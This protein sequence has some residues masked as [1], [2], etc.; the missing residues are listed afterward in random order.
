LELIDEQG[1][2]S[3]QVIEGRMNIT[4]HNAVLT[5]LE[6]RANRFTTRGKLPTLDE[7]LLSSAL[8]KTGTIDVPQCVE[9]RVDGIWG[10]ESERLTLLKQQEHNNLR[11]L[12]IT[13]DVQRIH[14][15]LPQSKGEGVIRLIYENVNGVNNRLCNN[16]KVEKAKELIDE[17]E[18]DVVAYNKH[19]LN[20]RHKNNGNG[21][22]QLFRGGEAAI[23]S[24]VALIFTRI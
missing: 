15:V 8:D 9:D 6:A 14:G 1:N 24:V 12:S 17:L 11:E 10:K 5:A 22:N 13:D 20:M 16:D 2:H 19:R 23:Q 3:T 4:S 18:A 21:F 7:R